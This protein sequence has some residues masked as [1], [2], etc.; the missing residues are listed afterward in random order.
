AASGAPPAPVPPPLPPPS[1][2]SP[3]PRSKAPAGLPRLYTVVPRKGKDFNFKIQPLENG[4]QAIIVT[5]RGILNVRNVPNVG[6]LDMEADR[7][8]IW[9]Q[10][11]D[12]QQLMNS[13][14][15]EG[16]GGRDL[17]FYLAGNVEIRQE[18]PT[19]RE[20]KTLRADEVYYDVNRNVA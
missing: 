11:G 16:H 9:T 2:P 7:L 14:R 15:Q 6:L 19:A 8:V 18:A 13:L 10:G 5:D 12:P 3:P 17:E 4:E 1:R 20:K